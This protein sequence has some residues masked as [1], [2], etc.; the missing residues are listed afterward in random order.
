MAKVHAAMTMTTVSVP[1]C[2]YIAE[3][4][5]LD[6]MGWG[7]LSQLRYHQSFAGFPLPIRLSEML[8]LQTDDVARWCKSRQLNVVRHTIQG[9]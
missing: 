3:E 4:I 9:T 2:K 1:T 6:I 5:A 8:V 7:D